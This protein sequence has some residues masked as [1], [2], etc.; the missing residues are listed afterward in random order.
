MPINTS[1]TLKGKKELDIIIGMIMAKNNREIIIIIQ[2]EISNK[3][4]KKVIIEKI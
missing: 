1:K 2:V 4:K 3:T